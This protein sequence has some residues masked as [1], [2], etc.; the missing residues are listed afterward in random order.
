[1]RKKYNK[2]DILVTGEKL[3]RERGYHN[4]GINDILEVCGIPKGSFYNF[5]KS[6]EDFCLQIIAMYAENLTQQYRNI[7]T[8]VEL[9]PMIRIRKLYESI[10]AS[11]VEDGFRSGSLLTNLA[12]EMGALYPEIGLE[13]NLRYQ[14]WLDVITDCV[15]EGQKAGEIL[16]EYPARVIAEYLHNSFYG[17]LALMKVQR[18]E[19][20]L[21]ISLR[22]GLAF[23]SRDGSNGHS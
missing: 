8:D 6:K 12:S 2:E 1:M 11:H 22:L 9:R 23:I 21:E 15:E 10:M 16:T 7:L 3:V 13:I 19:K 5:F 17:S 18:S 4:T 14:Q 20:P